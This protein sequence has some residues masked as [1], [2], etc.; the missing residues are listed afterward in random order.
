MSAIHPFLN[1][2]D[3]VNNSYFDRFF[4]QGYGSLISAIN[5]INDIANQAFPS[6][7]FRDTFP[8]ML[9]PSS[10]SLGNLPSQ[11]VSPSL[12]DV[13]IGDMPSR[14]ILTTSLVATDA[15]ISSQISRLIT[16]ITYRLDN[17]TG[18]KQSVE[19]GIWNRAIDRANKAFRVGYDKFL[20]NNSSM[21]W[22]RASG[23]DKSAFIGM[24][25]SKNIELGSINRDIAEKQADLEQ[26]NLQNALALLQQFQAQLFDQKN[27]DE[28]RKVQLYQVDI[29]KVLKE[30]D[31]YNTI[32]TGI[33]SIYTGQVQAYA[34]VVGA[35]SDRAKM[36]LS[37]IE[38]INN[39]NM[40]LE[41]LYIERIKLKVQH[42]DAAYS[43]N[44]E[45]IK[46]A[47]AVLSQVGASL[48]NALNISQSFGT[49]KSWSY[50]ESVST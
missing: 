16:D 5:K 38:T 1:S 3:S 4:D 46:G 14:P 47:A 35:E 13:T 33:I 28:S 31:L 49:S 10:V 39:L 48:F 45:A 9:D 42:D 26:Q 50:G 44:I 6:I 36:E 2:I 18:L 15:I 40:Q 37:R 7:D 25:N 43:A 29:D 23:S 12:R 30:A 11:P 20:A 8:N 21:G 24:E 17:P 19:Q 32:N 22:S 41:Q 27:N 34:A